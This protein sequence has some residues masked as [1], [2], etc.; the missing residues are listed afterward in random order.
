MNKF[1]R[2]DAL[3]VPLKTEYFEAFKAGS[4]TVEYRRYGRGWNEHTCRVGRSVTLSKGYGKY[5]RLSGIVVGFSRRLMAS[6][7]WLACYGVPGEAA[8]IRIKVL[9]STAQR[10]VSK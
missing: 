3:F 10:E 4:K 6:K 5:S 8:C 1:C 7:A 2:E 9:R